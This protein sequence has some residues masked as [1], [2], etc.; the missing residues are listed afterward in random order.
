MNDDFMITLN[1]TIL[2]TMKTKLTFILFFLL[3]TFS[4]KKKKEEPTNTSSDNKDFAKT[5][6][7]L[8]K[9]NQLDHDTVTGT[10]DY[11]YDSFGRLLKRQDLNKEGMP[12]DSG[13][14]TYFTYNEN[15]LISIKDNVHVLIGKENSEPI[16]NSS[17][18]R[19]PYSLTEFSYRNDTIVSSISTSY[20][21]ENVHTVAV[22]RRYYYRNGNLNS[23]VSDYS[24]INSDCKSGKIDSTVFDNYLNGRAR[25]KIAYTLNYVCPSQGSI[26]Y[27]KYSESKLTF[28]G[29][30]NLIKVEEASAT[31]NWSF[32]VQNEYTYD[33]T[34]QNLNNSGWD[35]SINLNQFNKEID[36]NLRISEKEYSN[37]DCISSE[38]QSPSL[39][40]F[41]SDS[42]ILK[43]KYGLPEKIESTINSSYCGRTENY[44]RQKS[45]Q[46]SC[47]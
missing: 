40:Y 18:S 44:K 22:K 12:L 1:F 35:Y 15:K 11:Q 47:E 21:N 34:I 5:S 43:N 17:G 13:K 38:I 26:S 2:F 28:D 27:Q 14:Y 45:F 37:Y 9:E 7:L 24:T 33:L 41:R 25:T 31:T 39:I 30:M 20:Q 36:R 8:T 29:N 10:V 16:N 42:I 23:V 6:C 19:F 3:I 46:Y 4:C 32:W